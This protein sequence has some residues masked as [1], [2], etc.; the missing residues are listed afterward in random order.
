MLDTQDDSWEM[1][2]EK[3]P[4]AI[5]EK[6]KVIILVDLADILCGYDKIF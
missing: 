4:D 5:T 1:D 3:L 6:I 2:Y